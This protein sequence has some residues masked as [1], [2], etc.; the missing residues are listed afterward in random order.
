MGQPKSGSTILGVTLGNCTD[1]FFAGELCNWLA[2]S[3]KPVIGGAERIQFWQDV[4]R[5][6]EG[7]DDQF[8]TEAFEYLERGRSVFRLESR[9]ARRRL[10]GPYGR[11]TE[12]L[13]RSVADRAGATHVVDTSHL[14]L[15]A[16]E[17]QKMPGI[18]LRLIF[19]VRNVEGIVASTTRNKHR[20]RFL[21]VNA[22]LW[23]T[24]L[25]SVAIFL[26]SPPDRRVLVRHEDFVANPQGVLRDILDM[27]GSSAPIPDLTAL[28]TG[29][30]FNGNRLIRTETVALKTKAAEPRKQSRLMRLTQRP[31][32]MIL[33]RLQPVAGAS[34]DPPDVP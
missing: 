27:A 34:P 3:G 2:T 8:G 21:K 4:S 11:V 23:W 18:D 12:S 25:L 26:R 28:R 30:A 1:V 29:L 16:H 19:L 14:P 33:G 22:R 24:Y 32:T 5:R 13:F 9:R 15:R 6:V 7:S 17:L 10:R 20:S 31:W